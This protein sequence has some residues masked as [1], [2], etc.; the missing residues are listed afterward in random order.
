MAV[1]LSVAT[2]CDGYIDDNSSE[3]LVLSTP[4][5]WDEVYA[6]RT[7][8][9]AIVI[10]AQ[11]LRR[12]NPRL[13]LKSDARREQ[14]LSRG[15]SAEPYKVI[16]SSNGAID[17][18]MRIFDSPYDDVIIFSC[19]ERPELASR[20]QIIVTGQITPQFII[21][22]LEKRGLYNIMVEGGAKI[23]SLFLDAH[24]ADSLRIAVNPT[25][26]VDDPLAPRFVRPE[27]LAAKERKRRTLDGMEIEEYELKGDHAESDTRYLR[28]AIELSRHCQPSATSYCVG[29]VVV[30]TGGQIFE[31][32]THESSP[33]HH[34]EQEAIAKAEAAGVI[35]EG[36]TIYS[37]MEPCSERSSEPESC[38]A[39]I[40][41]HRF[42]RAVF[43][44][45]EPSH[46]VVCRGALNM[47]L[48]G[49]EVVCL[50]DL[51]AEVL[52][53]NKHLGV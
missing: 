25:V 42:A 17:P 7:A 15:L 29:A 39:I 36:A 40:I 41:R 44:L 6:L 10:G 35:L 9:D 1:I 49:V 27:W 51:G 3:R 24:C 14:R 48:S 5:D 23:L 20:A 19:V 32:Y 2:S 33:T 38:S 11:T 18:S 4:Q 37:S 12:D 21:T 30:T 16:I 46:F 22:E 43:A 28:R 8:A 47:R 45:Y 31:G 52:A 26:S 50:S 34:A 13:S 53:I